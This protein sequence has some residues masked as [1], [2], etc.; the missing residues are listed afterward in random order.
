M[1]QLTHT[2][3]GGW[4]MN[5]LNS[6]LLEGNLVADP[7]IATTP[8][9]T[10]VCNFTIATHRFTRDGENRVKEVSYFDV[11]VWAKLAQQCGEFL[12]KGR[13]VRVVGRL[14]QD[15]WQ[16]PEG[17]TRSRVKLVGEHVEFRP[18]FTP[19]QEDPAVE[20]EED[21]A[22]DVESGR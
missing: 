1:R 21:E 15:R 5:N 16:D 3:W 13:G 19:P 14:K 12:A 20:V 2:I 11:E 9:G 4:E 7:A 18:H 22:V 10:P 6:V 8:K 17:N